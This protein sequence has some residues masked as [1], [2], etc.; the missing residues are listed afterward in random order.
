MFGETA[1]ELGDSSGLKTEP[2]STP[3]K[4]QEKATIGETAQASEY[5][6]P[7]LDETTNVERDDCSVFDDK[8]SDDSCQQCNET[9]D[10]EFHTHF[11]CSEQRRRVVIFVLPSE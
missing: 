3:A 8:S 6:I 10:C 1:Q 2:Q 11:Q 9:E 7:P 5:L 4:R